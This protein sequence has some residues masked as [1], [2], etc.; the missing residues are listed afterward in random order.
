MIDSTPTASSAVAG[1]G[2]TRPAESVVEADAG[3]QAAEPLQDALTQAG[4]GPCS[5]ALQGEQVLGRPEDRFDPL[6]D[7]REMGPFAGLIGAPGTN[8]ADAQLAGRGGELPSGAALVTDHDLAAAGGTLEELKRHLTLV[9]PG[10][11]HGERPR[12]TVGG[13]QQM[14]TKAPVPA[15]VGSTEAV[16]GDL[17]ESRAFGRLTTAAA[18]KGGSSR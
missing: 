3:S 14:E 11:G 1:Q 8:H 13:G 16:A 4:Q 10:I 15:R 17:S 7:L 18:L 6:A 9:A 12:C 2:A 5:V